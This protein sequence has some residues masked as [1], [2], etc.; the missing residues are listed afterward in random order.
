VSD[1]F[2]IKFNNLSK[3]YTLGN[4]NFVSFI[5]KNKNLKK[6]IALDNICFEIY[7][8][9]RIAILGKNGSGKST[10]LKILSRITT[11]T[12]G[13]IIVK[14]RV[15]SML[16]TGLGFHPELTTIENIYLNASMLGANDREIKKSLDLIINF[17]GLEEFLHVPLKK[18]SSGMIS[19]LGFSIGIFL[20]SEI[21]IL[22]EILSVVD[23]QFRKKCIDKINELGDNFNKTLLFVS[24]NLDLV[25]SI[26][27]TGVVLNNGK[28]VYH[29][30]IDDALNLYKKSIL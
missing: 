9:E 16:E 1:N 26:C 7:P 30:N 8:K 21:L 3:E 28:L 20:P 12:A 10:L 25:K 13:E 22:D 6:K 2:L 23:G 29:G 17:A 11:P 18:F 19:K 14:G 27:K 5:Q 4:I 15:L 24:H